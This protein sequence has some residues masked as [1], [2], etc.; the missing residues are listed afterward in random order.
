MLFPFAFSPMGDRQEA[1]GCLWETYVA[2]PRRVCSLIDFVVGGPAGAR[3][4]PSNFFV[5]LDGLPGFPRYFPFVFEAGNEYRI[6]VSWPQ[7]PW[8]RRLRVVV[9]LKGA[10][11]W[12]QIAAKVEG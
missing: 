7:S 9:W 11:E 8:W 6:K 2:I 3:F 10:P 4:L 5:D 12:P 1:D